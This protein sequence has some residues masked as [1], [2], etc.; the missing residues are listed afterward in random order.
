MF[1][2]HSGNCSQLC[3]YCGLIITINLLLSYPHNRTYLIYFL[4][5][6]S[7]MKFKNQLFK[8]I[9]ETDSEFTESFYSKIRSAIVLWSKTF[10]SLI[11]WLRQGWDVIGPAIVFQ[12]YKQVQTKRPT[13]LCFYVITSRP[14]NMNNKIVEIV[15]LE[16]SNFVAINGMELPQIVS[17]KVG[18]FD[19][20]FL[21]YHVRGACV[22]TWQASVSK[23][24]G[25][26]AEV[27]KSGC[28]ASKFSNQLSEHLVIHRDKT[29][30]AEKETS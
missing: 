5:N 28:E 3:T 1:N 11:N 30:R 17:N 26:G 29:T 7:R 22:R 25:G 14:R 12:T 4:F 6:V 16:V 23:R 21:K 18:F 27:E 10:R 19:L 13:E 2:N 15:L 8:E 9:W 20:M 24:G